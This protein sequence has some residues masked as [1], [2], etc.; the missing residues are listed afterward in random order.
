M[1]STYGDRNHADRA[2]IEDK[3]ADETS[4]TLKAGGNMLVPTFA[5]ERAQELLYH[6]SRLTRS[7]RLPVVPVFLDSPMALDATEVMVRH[8]ECLDEQTL[9]LL[10]SNESPFKFPGL[11]LMRSADES[12]RLNGRRGCVILAGSGM[13]NAGR[14]KH[15]LVHNIDKPESTVLFV[16]YQ[17]EGTLGREIVDRLPEVRI[18]G[19]PYPVKARIAEISGLSAHADQR[20][21]LRW[22]DAFG[23]SPR[24]LFLTHGEERVAN[25]LAEIIRGRVK[26][27]VDVPGYMQQFDLA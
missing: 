25:T 9:A 12:K 26:Y 7:G 2:L 5:I 4:H 27:P 3:I 22:L 17:A 19:K 10:R 16:G 20:A 13:C 8:P 24:G 21:L 6:F 15:H 14:I 23:T 11:H 1:E 18:L